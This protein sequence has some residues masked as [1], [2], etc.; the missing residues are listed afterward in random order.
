MLPHP[1]RR[2]LSRRRLDRTGRRKLQRQRGRREGGIACVA[3]VFEERVSAALVARVSNPCP[4]S[5]VIAKYGHGLQTRAT[6]HMTSPQPPKKLAPWKFALGVLAFVLV[7]GGSIGI[8]LWLRP[9]RPQT[10]A[11]P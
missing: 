9:P 10:G 6:G 2:R 4:S 7:V 5:S 1:D 11:L 3:G 8:G